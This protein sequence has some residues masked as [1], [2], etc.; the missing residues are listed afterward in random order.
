MSDPN[1]GPKCCAIRG[2]W[3]SRLASKDPWVVDAKGT[4]AYILY[5]LAEGGLTAQHVNQSIAALRFL[6]GQVLEAPRINAK[7]PRPRGP[8]TLPTVLGR[9]EVLV[10]IRAIPKVKYRTASSWPIRRACG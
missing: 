2:L 9:D 6:S 4:K 5:M 8:W 1:F 10:L 7:M 3:K